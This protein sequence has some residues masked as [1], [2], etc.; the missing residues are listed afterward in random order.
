MSL[1]NEFGLETTCLLVG[2]QIEQLNIA[3]NN[4]TLSYLN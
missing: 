3:C 4:V 2:A 1:A